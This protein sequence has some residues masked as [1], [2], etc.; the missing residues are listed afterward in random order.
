MVDKDFTIIIADDHPMLLNG[1]YEAL[2]S[3]GYN[4]IGKAQNGTEA[5]QLILELKPTLAILDVEMP[6]M[7]GFEVVKH[8]REKSIST[9]FIIQT[10][11][12]NLE[13]ITLAL[14]LKI[15][16]YLLKE[17][18]FTAI[19]TCMEKVLNN[20]SYFSDSIDSNGLLNA[21]DEFK[22]LKLLTPSELVILKLISKRAST[23]VIAESLFVSTRTIEKHRSN[24]ID[25]LGLRG[26]EQN[27]LSYWAIAHFK[28]ISTF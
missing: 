15:E 5:L 9:K 16:G 14:S 13:Y 7:T 1:L 18:P 21:T 8:I 24:I 6:F 2:V 20:E 17:D 4:V 26:G 19:E 23:N 11:H 22:N 10:L 28:V 12:K 25:K 3:N 27:S